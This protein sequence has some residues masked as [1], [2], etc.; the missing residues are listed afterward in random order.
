MLVLFS[1]WRILLKLCIPVWKF[2]F[3]SCETAISAF[4]VKVWVW[5]LCHQSFD[6]FCHSSIFI[7]SYWKAVSCSNGLSLK[8]S[9]IYVL[10]GLQM[11]A[12]IQTV[13]Q[14]TCWLGFLSYCNG[15]LITLYKCLLL[16]PLICFTGMDEVRKDWWA[17]DSS[18]QE[19]FWYSTEFL[20]E[21]GKDHG[22]IV[23]LFYYVHILCF[24]LDLW[25]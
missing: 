18:C 16:S 19:H 5:G 21:T 3:F 6:V 8:D 17:N 22:S 7:I 10:E 15:A 12:H 11:A 23:V 20:P 2:P 9:S 24:C 13:Q 1:F 14:Q 25:L 4:F